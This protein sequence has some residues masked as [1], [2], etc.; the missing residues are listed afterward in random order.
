HV[1][2]L[3][4][5]MV[6]A[7]TGLKRTVPLTSSILMVCTPNP[8][9]KSHRLCIRLGHRFL[10]ARSCS[11]YTS[12]G[13]AMEEKQ[14]CLNLTH[15]KSEAMGCETLSPAANQLMLC[16]EDTFEVMGPTLPDGCS[17]PSPDSPPNL[18]CLPSPTS[19]MS[20]T[21]PR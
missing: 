7:S 18:L 15:L 19:R 11:I 6:R 13:V 2:I 12:S 3:S 4:V 16:C 20:Q 21:S 10:T 5:S 9:T 17:R 8:L 1:K 14:A